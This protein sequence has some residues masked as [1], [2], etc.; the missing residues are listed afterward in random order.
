[1][2]KKLVCIILL[3][4]VLACILFLIMPKPSAT[5]A[6]LSIDGKVVKEFDLRTQ[7]G[8]TEN[9]SSYGANITIQVENGKIRVLESDCPDKICVHTGFIENFTQ[10]AVCLPNKA[11]LE[12]IE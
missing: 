1:M 5:K 12:I 10:T 9:F 7:E 8:F 11:I 3:F 6:R 4:A 2:K